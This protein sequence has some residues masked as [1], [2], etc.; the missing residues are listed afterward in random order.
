VSIHHRDP[1]PKILTNVPEANK[2][3][4]SMSL[5]VFVSDSSKED[6]PD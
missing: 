1:F 5:T 3:I 4:L 2:I 6:K